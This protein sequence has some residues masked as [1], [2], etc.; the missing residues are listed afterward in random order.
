LAKA[1]GAHVT[2]MC[3][4]SKIDLVAGLGADEVVDYTPA[5]RCATSAAASAC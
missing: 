4:T 3:R 2:G 1:Y 5:H